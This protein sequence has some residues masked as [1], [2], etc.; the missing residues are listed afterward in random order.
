MQY[1]KLIELVKNI[2]DEIN[3]NF[4]DSVHKKGKLKKVKCNTDPLKIF[5]KFVLI[6]VSLSH[7]FFFAF[8]WTASEA[9]GNSQARVKSELHLLAYFTAT[10]AWDPSRL[11][12][13]A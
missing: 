1:F 3:I 10:A 7:S 6:M 4:R 5:L 13:M 12:P 2:H 11:W 8:F 9:Y